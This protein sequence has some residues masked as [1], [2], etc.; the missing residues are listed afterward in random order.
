MSSKLT[1]MQKL[2]WAV[3]IVSAL[4]LLGDGFLQFFGMTVTPAT[5][6]ANVEMGGWHVEQ[7]PVLGV[8]VTL[9]AVLYLIPRTAV[10]GAILATGFYAGAISS[11]LRIGGTPDMYVCMVM[12]ALV[13]GGLYLRDARIRELLPFV[14]NPQ[15]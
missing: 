1:T 7:T 4:A 10:L 11:E 13:W 5:M 14:A 6:R 8:I 12:A 2:G 15:R 9:A 3:T